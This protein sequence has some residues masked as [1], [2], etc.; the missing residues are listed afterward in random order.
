MRKKIIGILVMMLL[1]S[2]ALQTVG[3]NIKKEHAVQN[4]NGVEWDLTIDRGEF[5]TI[6]HVEQTTDGEYICCGITEESDEFYVHLLKIK[7]DGNV[8]WSVVNYNLNASYVGVSNSNIYA[9]YVIQTSDEGYLVT[10]I[11]EK[12]FEYQGQG[13]WIHVPYLWKTDSTGITEWIQ[14]YYDDIWNFTIDFFWCVKEVIDGYM[15]SGFK[16]HYDEYGQ[17]LDQNGFLTKTDKTGNMI[18]QRTYN[19]GEGTADSISSLYPTNSG[20]YLLSGCTW[21]T[22]DDGSLWMIKTDGDGIEEWNE[23]F[24]GSSYDVSYARDCFETSDG[25]GIMCGN[26]ESYGAGLIDVWVIKTNASGKKDWDKTYGDINKDY[27]WD[28]C[29]TNDGGYVI[30]ICKNYEYTGDTKGDI[31][32]AKTTEDGNTEW[33]YIIEE[34]NNQIPTAVRQ[35]SDGG[36][37]VAG[38]T[39]NMGSESTNGI[40][41]KISAIGNKRPNKPEKPDGPNKG[42]PDTEYTFTT[43]TTDPD[44]DQLSYLWDWG[45]GNFTEGNLEESHIWTSENNFNIKVKAIDEHGAESEWSDSL[46][47]STPK[48]KINYLFSF[49]IDRLIKLYNEFANTQNINLK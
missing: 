30:A 25:G 29:K 1:I 15:V 3:T 42:K 37:I 39:G 16:N 22:D 27:T 5:D 33:N 9:I 19:L 18:W 45:D 41:Y 10:G 49:I 47:F 4:L 32:L 40:L 12:Y 8:N 43:S 23:V 6:R 26:T 36:Y 14:Q 34:D 2:T 24:D 44:G 13:I 31:W 7:S 35:T 20:G 46:S 28:M 48:K 21:S 17:T 11:S 38:R